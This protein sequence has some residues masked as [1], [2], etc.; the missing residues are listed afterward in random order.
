M[1]IAPHVLRPKC[2]CI[3]H[4]WCIPSILFRS[5]WNETENC[6]SGHSQYNDSKTVSGA[7]H[8]YRSELVEHFKV[9]H[10]RRVLD[11]RYHYNFTVWRAHVHRIEIHDFQVR[12]YRFMQNDS[13]YNAD[14][15]CPN[16]VWS[17]VVVAFTNTYFEVLLDNSAV[18]FLPS[19]I[20]VNCYIVISW[21]IIF[22]SLFFFGVSLIYHH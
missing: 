20:Q 11:V 18:H 8:L 16:F 4:S 19:W 9:L 13:A 3:F 5:I 15:G 6:A 2:T 21:F 12:T 1:T 22:L 7:W 10:F 14:I 17:T